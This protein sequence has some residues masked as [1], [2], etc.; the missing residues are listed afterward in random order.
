MPT[1]NVMDRLNA[2]EVLL[3]DGAT[4]SELHRR[5]AQ[6]LVDT[7]AETGQQAWSATANIDYADVVQQV[8]QDY[9]RVGAEVI[10]SNNFWTIPFRLARIG[11]ED[12]W[13]EYARAAMRNAVAARNAMNPDAYVAAGIAPPGASWIDDQKPDVEAEEMGREEY[14][15]QYA[16]HANLCVEEGADILLPEYVG[17]IADCVEA[18]DACAEAGVPVWLSVRHINAEDGSMQYGES[19]ADL[20]KALEGHPVDAILLMCSNPQAITAGLKVLIPAFDGI[21]GAYPNLGY[22]PLA[23]LREPETL[24][25]QLPAEGSDFIQLGEYSPSRTAEFAKEWKDMG[26]LIIGGCCAS[27][28]EHVMAIKPVIEAA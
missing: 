13:E 22:A 27:G 15:R 9:L 26:A 28:P 8:H 25:N 5:G 18:V 6:V 2:G 20:A 19:L 1:R 12:R 4:G 23:Q 24:S 16:D 17:W 14:H 10:I 7:T 11:L 3:M 21:V